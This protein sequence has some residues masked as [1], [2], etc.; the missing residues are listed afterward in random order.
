MVR[1]KTFMDI[2]NNYSKIVT[3]ITKLHAKKTTTR[4]YS[5]QRIVIEKQ[6]NN[7]L[8]LIL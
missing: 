8:T 6:C 3:D 2:L 1:L 7:G 5:R 4:L